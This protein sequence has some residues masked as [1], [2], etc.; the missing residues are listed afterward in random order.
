[1][2]CNPVQ[3]LGLFATFLPG[4]AF[5]DFRGPF[6][7]NPVDRCQSNPPG[8]GFKVTS[9]TF[10]TQ[11]DAHFELHGCLE[12]CPQTVPSLSCWHVIY[13]KSSWAG[14]THEEAAELLSSVWKVRAVLKQ[15]VR[16]VFTEAKLEGSILK[17]VGNSPVKCFQPE[18]FIYFTY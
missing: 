1:M 15:H 2:T 9:V 11:F 4:K 18:G 17:L 3:L 7:A 8:T 5:L 12:P 10:L 13:H 16:R 6:S 14:V